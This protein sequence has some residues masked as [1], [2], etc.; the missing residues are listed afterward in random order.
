M[1]TNKQ[2][3]LVKNYNQV[4]DYL[5]AESQKETFISRHIDNLNDKILSFVYQCKKIKSTDLAKCTLASIAEAFKTSLDIGIP[6][7]ATQKAY[8]LVYGNELTYQIGYKG[9]LY[10]VRKFRPGIYIEVNLLYKDDEFSYQSQSG[11][12]EYTYKPKNP[13]RADFGQVSG[14]FVFMSWLQ[15][16]R[17]YSCIHT[18]SREE[19]DQARK[20]SKA[21]NYGP[22]NSWPGEMMKKVILRRACKIE[23]IGDPE[24]EAVLDIDNREYNF[25]NRGPKASEQ[26]KAVNY[27]DVQPLEEPT[28]LNAETEPKQP[29]E[30]IEPELVNDREEE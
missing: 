23:F 17:E 12:A 6:V 2:L 29:A 13:T 4:G 30:I 10:K 5:R 16:G 9:L 19:I 1:E 20:A 22:W 7:D 15:N 8:L 18:M 21:G 25:D 26:A 14:G 28:I 11:K 24:M 3:A 27:G